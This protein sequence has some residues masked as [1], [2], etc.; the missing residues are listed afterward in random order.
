MLSSSLGLVN[1]VFCLSGMIRSIWFELGFKD[2][3]LVVSVVVGA[4][5]LAFGTQVWLIAFKFDW[6]GLNEVTHVL[7]PDAKLSIISSENKKQ[8]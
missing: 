7:T 8:F 5:R 6:G 1:G 2:K 4:E 3:L